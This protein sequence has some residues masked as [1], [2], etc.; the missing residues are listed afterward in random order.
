MQL[1]LGTDIYTVQSLLAHKSVTT[2]QIYARHADPKRREAANR[3][4]LEVLNNVTNIKNE[5]SET[6]TS[7]E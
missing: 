3:M 7:D 1:E 5:S 4:S 6:G 2:T